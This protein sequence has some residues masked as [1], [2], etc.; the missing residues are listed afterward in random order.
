MASNELK[1]R[2]AV[3]RVRD[4]IAK[5][6]NS[7]IA[8]AYRLGL[9]EKEIYMQPII[10]GVLKASGLILSPDPKND[11]IQ[12]IFQVSCQCDHFKFKS[13]SCDRKKSQCHSKRVQGW[14]RELQE[15]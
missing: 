14:L 1:E 7:D 15:L 8:I 5:Y 4:H 10:D 2:K 9:K 6:P 11:L 13:M 3:E 12:K